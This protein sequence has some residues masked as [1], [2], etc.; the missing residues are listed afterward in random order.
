MFCPNCAAQNNASQHY[1]RTCGIK[2]DEIA[3]SLA[4]QR[5]SEEFARLMQR[6]RRFELAGIL[7]LSTA[8]I[9]GLCLVIAAVFYYKLQWVGPEL[10]FRSASIALVLFTLL[11]GIFLSYPKIA[12]KFESLKSRVPNPPKNEVEAVTTSKLIEDRPFEPI[13]SATEDS[14]E[15]LPIRSKTTKLR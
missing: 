11:S 9:I 8:G 2:L 10:L 5:P 13:P 15:L 12:K 1:C 4:S 6:K 14:T 3:E 7:C